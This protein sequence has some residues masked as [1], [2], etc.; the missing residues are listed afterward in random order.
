MLFSLIVIKSCAVYIRKI[1]EIDININYNNV[2]HQF[3][4]F[5][6]QIIMIINDYKICYQFIT[7]LPFIKG[8]TV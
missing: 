3:T 2:K 7:C 8:T 1:S 5:K 6:K 4:F